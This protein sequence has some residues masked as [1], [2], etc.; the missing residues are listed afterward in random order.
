M[1][2]YPVHAVHHPVATASNGQSGTS[3][4]Y[5]CM[6]VHSTGYY[7]DGVHPGRAMLPLCT[8]SLLRHRSRVALPWG[9]HQQEQQQRRRSRRHALQEQSGCAWQWNVDHLQ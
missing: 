6:A 7:I 9:G 5:E 3:T 2:G 8:W 4:T 1:E